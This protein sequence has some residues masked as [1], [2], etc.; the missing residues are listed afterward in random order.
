MLLMA[1]PLSKDG[2]GNL[3]MAHPH[4]KNQGRAPWPW[5][6]DTARYIR[7]KRIIE[8]IVNNSREHWRVLAY[9]NIPNFNIPTDSEFK[10][11]GHQ[12]VISAE[13]TR[14]VPQLADL[15]AIISY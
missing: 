14:E 5:V 11:H 1:L 10:N 7:S 3:E 9:F 13:K 2:V 6:C 15:G 4:T 12:E 8:R